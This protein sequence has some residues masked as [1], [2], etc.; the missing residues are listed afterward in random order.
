MANEAS[1]GQHEYRRPV[2]YERCE[3]QYDYETRSY[4]S[5]YRVRYEYDG[6]IF[7]TRTRT[8]PGEVIRL[9][10]AARPVD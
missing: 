1:R 9:E 6:E 10:I 5:G 4:T 7:E 8:E 2:S 3:I